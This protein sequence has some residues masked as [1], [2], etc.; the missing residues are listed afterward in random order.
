MLAIWYVFVVLS[1]LV[2]GAIATSNPQGAALWSGIMSIL[3]ISAGLGLSLGV[4]L[5]ATVAKGIANGFTLFFNPF[6]RIDNR[7]ADETVRSINV[8]NILSLCAFLSVHAAIIVAVAL[9]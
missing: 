2:S 9:Q 6:A 4:T 8:V 7:Q 5:I 3:G 1:F